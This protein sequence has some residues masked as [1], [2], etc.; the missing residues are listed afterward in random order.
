V[1]FGLAEEVRQDGAAERAYLTDHAASDRG[2]DRP[3]E[4]H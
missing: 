1:L 4:R 3:A 2:G